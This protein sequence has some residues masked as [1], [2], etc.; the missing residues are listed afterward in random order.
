MVG[1]GR[2]SAAGSLVAYLLGITNLDPMEHGLL[3]ERFLNPER[4]SMP[5]IDIDFCFERRGEVIAY[6]RNVLG[7]TGSRRLLPSGPWRPR[8]RSGMWDALWAY[9]MARWT[10]L[11]KLIP[12]E[13]GITL[14][15]AKTQSTEIRS[16]LEKDPR[17]EELWAIA[18]KVEGFPRHASTHAAGVVIAR[19]R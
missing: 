8:R 10:E 4:I 1:P 12:N 19:N 3:F 14:D 5:D 18:S 7:L 6:V 15:E 17:L 11:A 13:L 2:G 9:L 16:A